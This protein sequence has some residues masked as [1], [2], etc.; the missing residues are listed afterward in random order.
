MAQA[1]LF[2]LGVDHAA[3]G[4]D[5]PAAVAV[6]Q[7][8]DG[9]PRVVHVE[10]GEPGSRWCMAHAR[11]E[12]GTGVAIYIDGRIAKFMCEAAAAE[13]GAEKWFGWPD[14]PAARPGERR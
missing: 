7:G 1:T 6:E 12:K 9:S 8:A 14:R 10:H 3:P 2:I 13:R 5:Q 4:A 11:F